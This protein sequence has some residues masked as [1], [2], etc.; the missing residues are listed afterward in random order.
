MPK[1][2]AKVKKPYKKRCKVAFAGTQ[3]DSDEEDE[4][5]LDQIGEEVEKEF[6]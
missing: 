2:R 4:D 5:E 1:G 3:E 6:G